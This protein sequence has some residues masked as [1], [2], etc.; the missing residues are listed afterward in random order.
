[1]KRLYV[2]FLLVMVSGCSM[3]PS[4]D[5][6]KTQTANAFA[7]YQE[8]FLH[9]EDRLAKLELKRAIQEASCSTDLMPLARIYLGKC[10]LHI[11]V[12]ED[13]SCPDYAQVRDLPE[14]SG[15][16]NNYFLM[17]QHRIDEVD[18]TMLPHQYR[19]YVRQVKRRDYKAAFSCIRKMKETSS[20]LIAAAL[21][22]GEL[23]YGMIGY[24][25]DQASFRGY[26]KAVLAWL[27]FARQAAPT[28][29]TILIDK[30]LNLLEN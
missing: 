6:W 4:P 28:G 10:A 26:K 29:D 9:G 1:M 22:K 18:P 27:R 7:S 17:L 11:A 3:K 25:L 24:I 13:T 30:K 8:Y 21:I 5:K 15:E 19:E 12:L 16:L 14:I 20:K 2:L 23:D